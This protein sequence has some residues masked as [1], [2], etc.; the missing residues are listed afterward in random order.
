MVTEELYILKHKDLDVAMVKINT[1]SGRIE[2]ILEIYLPEELPVGCGYDGTGLIEWWNM[3][4]V[5]DTRKGIQQALRVLNKETPQSLMLATYGLSLTDHYWM[6]P[7][8]KEL[9]WKDINFFENDFSDELGD[10]LTDTGRIDIEGHIS[11]FSPTSSVN[12]EM[13]KKWIIRDGKRY[14][15]KINA[16]SYGQQAVNEK[17]ASRLHERLKW[18][19]YNPYEI[20]ITKTEREEIPCSL[21]E[22]FTSLDMELVSA[23]QLIRNYKVPNDLS[24][25]EAIIQLAVNAGLNEAE[26]RTQLEYIIM[27]DFILSNTDR[28]YNNFGFLYSGREHCLIKMAPIYDTGNCLFYGEDSVP[29]KYGLL[30]IKVS[31]FCKKEAN[32]LSYIKN[33]ELINI[34]KLQGFPKEA[35]ELLTEYTKVPKPRVEKIAETIEKKIEYLRLFQE[36]KKI[37]KREK[38]W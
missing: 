25:Y 27:T 9:Y 19:N 8:S 4:A 13:K 12:G 5:P 3:R 32:M 20:G 24:E 35:E 33:K 29:V 6:R 30:S 38:Y 37:W 1:L 22:M 36:G 16:N 17:I 14:L 15:M 2:Y 18:K 28:H 10:L 21:N 34:Q 23:Y 7:I 31:S 11:L 26:V